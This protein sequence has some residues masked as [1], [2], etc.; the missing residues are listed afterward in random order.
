MWA[1]LVGLITGIG[2]KSIYDLFKDEQIPAP[3]GLNAGR[4]E[5]MLDETR[6][7]VRDLREELR[8]AVA[9]EGS[10]QEKAGRALSAAG[11]T[12]GVGDGGESRGGGS[13]AE[14]GPTGGAS[15][16]SE[17]AS[18]GAAGGES[19]LMLTA[20]EPAGGTGDST[21]GGSSAGS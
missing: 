5:S 14:S 4:V 15:G 8:Q 11:Q 21:G 6:Q 16:G 13:K 2:L 17:D 3:T 20:S 19:G 1:F 10:L 18:G 9:G 7:A 12:L